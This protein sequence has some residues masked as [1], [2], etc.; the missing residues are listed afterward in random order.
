M[1]ARAP[2]QCFSRKCLCFCFSRSLKSNES[3]SDDLSKFP[4]FISLVNRNYFFLI[5][6]ANKLSR[7]GYSK[8]LLQRKWQKP[9]SLFFSHFPLDIQSFSVLFL[10]AW[11]LNLKKRLQVYIYNAYR[12]LCLHLLFNNASHDLESYKIHVCYLIPFSSCTYSVVWIELVFKFS[13]I[14]T[15]FYIVLSCATQIFNLVHN[16]SLTV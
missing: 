11:T 10:F 9:S 16:N 14:S 7:S 3:G 6:N 8:A 1:L 15:R 13:F 2:A 5:S 4:R 12:L